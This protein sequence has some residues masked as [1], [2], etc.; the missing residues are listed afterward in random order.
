MIKTVHVST[1]AKNC[2]KYEQDQLNIVGYRM[3][4]KRN[5]RKDGCRLRQ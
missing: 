4:T 5:E 1:E 3:V 2:A